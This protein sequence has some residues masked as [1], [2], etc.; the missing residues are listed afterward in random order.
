MVSAVGLMF[1]QIRPK[2]GK[3]RV[4][5][6][7]KRNKNTRFRLQTTEPYV[8]YTDSIEARLEVHASWSGIR[9]RV[10]KNSIINN[11]AFPS[12][13]FQSERKLKI[14]NIHNTLYYNAEAH[15]ERLERMSALNDQG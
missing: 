5:G 3:D 9:V 14:F 10:F 12:R 1:R 8:P 2:T 13:S 6:M 15:P 4:W 7:S 11:N